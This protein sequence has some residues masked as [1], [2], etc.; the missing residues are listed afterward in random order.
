MTGARSGVASPI[1]NQELRVPFTYCYDHSLQLAVG[2]MIKRI[3]NI[4]DVMDATSEIC[5]KLLKYS[6]KRNAMFRKLKEDISSETSGFRKFC[7]NM[8]S[9]RA[10]S[11]KSV[12]D[13]WSKFQKLWEECLETNLK[14]EVR[15]R[16]IGLK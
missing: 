13:N 14:R 5:C 1:K 16:M 11:L 15:G 3:K 8:W 7:P 10:S 4:K 12:L 2:D 6:P 9:G